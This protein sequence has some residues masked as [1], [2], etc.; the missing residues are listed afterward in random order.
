MPPEQ[1]YFIMG[2]VRGSS[3][4]VVWDAMLGDPRTGTGKILAEC[5]SQL[6]AEEVIRILLGREL[7]SQT[8]WYI[9]RSK[10]AYG[11]HWVEDNSLSRR[12]TVLPALYHRSTQD[13]KLPPHID[14]DQTRPY[15]G[16]T[17]QVTI[18]DGVYKCWAHILRG[19]F[20]QGFGPHEF[21][22]FQRAQVFISEWNQAHP[23]LHADTP[24]FR[25][26]VGKRVRTLPLGEEHV[27]PELSQLRWRQAVA[28]KSTLLGYWDWVKTEH[29]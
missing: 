1:H 26:S 18:Q 24:V 25:P 21:G 11:Y 20:E 9:V 8:R 5:S 17:I 6:E 13:P 12:N 29:S 28:S 7:F 16:H 10:L 14:L 2:T 22:A 19:T 23:E 3:A 4:S 15:G 27:R